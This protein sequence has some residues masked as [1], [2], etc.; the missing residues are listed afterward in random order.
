MS[1]LHIGSADFHNPEGLKAILSNKYKNRYLLGD[2]IDTYE[3]KWE[4]IYDKNRNLIGFI[5]SLEPVIVIGNHDPKPHAMQQMFPNSEIY[6]K[7][8]TRTING[9]KTIMLH[10]DRYNIAVKFY[11]RISGLFR[12]KRF[13][14][15]VAHIYENH[16][17]KQFE[18]HI[19]GRDEKRTIK[20]LKDE[21][22]Q[23]IMGHTHTP[24]IINTPQ[25]TYINVGCWI[26]NPSFVTYEDHNF[27]LTW[28]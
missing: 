20:N 26:K 1:D 24:K 21:Y 7:E 5:D 11:H 27:N 15:Y 3:S 8:Y 14:D 12:E 16:A 18:F 25:I 4:K 22:E 13:K 23:I 19:L 6:S 9:K 17:Y 2:I 28:V 10:G